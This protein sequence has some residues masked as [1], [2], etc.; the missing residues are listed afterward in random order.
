[1]KFTVACKEVFS[2]PFL[3]VASSKPLPI[4]S[5]PPVP[6][7]ECIRAPV[8]DIPARSLPLV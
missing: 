5:Q 3:P 4:S 7:P 8:S 1:V 6:A 2:L